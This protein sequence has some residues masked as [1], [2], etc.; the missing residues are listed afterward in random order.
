MSETECFIYENES[1]DNDLE[2]NIDREL[3]A[4]VKVNRFLYD[5]TEK[6]Y[7]NGTV[8]NEAWAQIGASLT[9]PLE[10]IVAEKRFYNLRQRFGK[11]RRKVMQTMP[12]SGAAADQPIYRPTWKL[13]KDLMFLKDIIKPRKTVSNYNSRVPVKSSM[14]PATN[15][16]TFLLINAHTDENSMDIPEES[17]SP[18]SVT[19]SPATPPPATPP[20]ATT[21]PATL[22]P[23]TLPAVVPF[24]TSSLATSNNETYFETPP[25]VSCRP[26]NNTAVAQMQRAVS[27]IS[28]KRKVSPCDSFA[29][30]KQREEDAV[31]KSLIEQ[32]KGLTNLATKIGQAIMAPSPNVLPAPTNNASRGIQPMLSAIEFAL[33]IIP[34][35][36]QLQCLIGVLQYINDFSKM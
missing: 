20:P 11:E 10:G 8:K 21:L 33:G 9:H 6:L 25:A 28:T 23:A 4:V 12:R 5:K 3:I 31:D 7:A 13:Y 16:D 35:Y 34:E 17:F 27:N 36:A 15:S 24:A 22:L 26:R 2:V 1:F 19:S 14:S 29:I 18:L 30:K 32:S